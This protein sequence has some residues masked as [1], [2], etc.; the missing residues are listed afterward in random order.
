MSS[1]THEET[2]QKLTASGN[3]V[4]LELMPAWAERVAVMD[5][6]QG[7]LGLRI[8]TGDDGFTYIIELVEGGQGA[9]CGIFN[10]GDRLVSVNHED[11]VGMCHEDVVQA[12]TK[13]H[14]H[15]MVVGVEDGDV[16]M[17]TATA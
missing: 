2:V 15:E 8:A 10:V 1:A 6:R 14:H 17:D 12:L 7:R 11:T 4:E 5:P 3:T 9:A 16:D 13:N